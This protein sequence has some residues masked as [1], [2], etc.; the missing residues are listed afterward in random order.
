[1][2][3]YGHYDTHIIHCISVPA[4]ATIIGKRLPDACTDNIPAETKQRL[5]R[6]LLAL[7]KPFRKAEDFNP[8]NCVFD[9][10]FKYWWDHEAPDSA[11]RCLEHS[12][13]YY[14]SR[15]L[16]RTRSDENMERFRASEGANGLDD[17]E[18][19]DNLGGS[20]NVE[21][22]EIANSDVPIV[23]VMVMCLCLFQ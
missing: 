5:Q 3:D 19:D 14:T 21:E 15:E 16:A 22:S 2:R 1:M 9:D 18:N 13:D 10:M 11:H 4:V 23:L 6:A 8:R 12:S 20:L 7:F 17:I